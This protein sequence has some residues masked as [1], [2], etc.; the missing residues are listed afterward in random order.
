MYNFFEE[1]SQKVAWFSCNNT[2]KV[3]CF[4]LFF[5]VFW[6]YK[7]FAYLCA[8][9]LFISLFKVS[10]LKSNINMRKKFSKYLHSLFHDLRERKQNTALNDFVHDSF[11]SYV[12]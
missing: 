8:E 10:S 9:K 2:L 1:W 3:L 7:I 5:F 6:N 4:F 12:L 11:N